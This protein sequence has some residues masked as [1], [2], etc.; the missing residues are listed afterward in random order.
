LVEQAMFFGLG[1]LLAG[2]A[3]LL[4]LPAFWRRA[5][6]LSAKRA[7][8]QAPLSEIE[9]IAERD[10][11]R[12]VHAVEVRRIELRAAELSDAA[13]THLAELGRRAAR[14][15]GLE[16][17][18]AK[19]E[20]ES[21]E[22]GELLAARRQ[23][24]FGLEA[25]L[26]AAHTALHDFSAR[27]DRADQAIYALTEQRQALDTVADEQRALIASL[28]T[29]AS[30]LE[31]RLQDAMADHAAKAKAAEQVRA[32][33]TAEVR[34]LTARTEAATAEAAAA[35][36]NVGRLEKEL[37]RHVEALEIALRQ[38]ATTRASLTASERQREE[39][40]LENARRLSEAPNAALEPN[41]A[42]SAADSAA[43]ARLRAA[44]ARL[45]ADFLRI[46]RAEPD[47]RPASEPEAPAARPAA[48][49]GSAAPLR[50]LQSVA[51]PER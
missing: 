4:V 40:L 47:G 39:A 14:I 43:D 45:G 1:F 16:R 24:V 23:E 44:I 11:L 19:S 13:A 6:R 8:L 25:E 34:E 30:G 41:P 50:Q 22:R 3:A 12:A 18:L 46:A 36:A 48:E 31:A 35:R 20:A 7:R 15:V 38:A 9:V 42:S 2:L 51:A 37:A 5:L 17:A 21:A 33:S 27:L 26:G 10:Q 49:G 32:R 28:D 29:R